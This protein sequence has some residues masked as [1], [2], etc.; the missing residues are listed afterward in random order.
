LGF[1][2]TFRFLTGGA[3]DSPTCHQGSSLCI[4]SA[5]RMPPK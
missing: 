3:A 2:S 5:W 4:S 1:T